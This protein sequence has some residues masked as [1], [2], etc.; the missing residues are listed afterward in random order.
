MIVDELIPKVHKKGGKLVLFNRF[1]IYDSLL[2]ETSLT[3]DEAKD[4]CVLTARRIISN[5]IG[6]LS[7]PHIREIVCSVL[8][9]NGYSKARLEYTR[10]GMPYKDIKELLE[11]YSWSNKVERLWIMTN[12]IENEY[13]EV[14]DL[15]EGFQE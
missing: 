4:I 12:K 5:H 3:D 13:N 1:K 7:G 14:K 8:A 6:W 15:I 2:K 10:I 9:E 11:G